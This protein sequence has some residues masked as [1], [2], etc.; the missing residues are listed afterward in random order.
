[1]A[2]HG[3]KRS[4]GDWRCL[5]AVCGRKPVVSKRSGISL[6]LRQRLL[7]R[8]MEANAKKCPLV[9]SGRSGSLAGADS[10]AAGIRQTRHRF[11]LRRALLLRP[12]CL[13]GACK[14]KG[15]PQPPSPRNSGARFGQPR[16]PLLNEM[17]S[18]RSKLPHR[19]DVA[20][21][22]LRD[23]RALVSRPFDSA[24]GLGWGE[25]FGHRSNR[26]QT[27]APDRYS[28]RPAA[29]N[30]SPTPPSP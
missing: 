7:E 23:R 17:R 9:Q 1:M 19:P 20:E 12:D 4:S 21:A 28:L 11:R 8:A 15:P 6:D 24:E 10:Q 29:R 2:A 14:Q 18:S 16:L 25:R 26:H 22:W 5:L 3:R 30:A 27:P 13:Q